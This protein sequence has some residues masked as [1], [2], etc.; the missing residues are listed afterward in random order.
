[1]EQFS[2]ESSPYEH[3]LTSSDREWLERSKRVA[4]PMEEIISHLNPCLVRVSGRSI[5]FA[6]HVEQLNSRS[7]CNKALDSPQGSFSP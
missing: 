6:F 4:V 2:N 7:M 3:V 1:M 5:E